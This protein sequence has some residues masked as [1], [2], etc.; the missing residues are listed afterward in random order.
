MYSEVKANAAGAGVASDTAVQDIGR[1][2]ALAS[3][4]AGVGTFGVRCGE[5]IEVDGGCG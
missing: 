1:G 2:N 5:G 3:V 4:D